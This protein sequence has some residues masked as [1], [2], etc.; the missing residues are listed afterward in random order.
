MRF[1]YLRDTLPQLPSTLD[2]KGTQD[3]L[4]Q[5]SAALSEWQ[6]ND[7]RA[8]GELDTPPVFLGTLSGNQ[9]ITANV[10]T[11]VSL[12]AVVDTHSWLASNIYT[13]KEAG[14]YRCSWVVGLADSGAIATSTYG[15]GRVGLYTAIAVGNGAA[16]DVC[17]SG[18]TIVECDGSATTIKLEAMLS[19]GTAPAIRGDAV[20]TWLSIDYLGRRAL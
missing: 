19:A 3:Y 7:L 20:R 10:M 8:I 15:Y 18:S 9:P 2:L 4:R 11:T 13:P 12:T 5:L 14:F 17:A 1:S 6:R 16:N